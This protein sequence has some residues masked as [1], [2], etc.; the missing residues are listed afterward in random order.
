MEVTARYRV[1][2]GEVWF[3]QA[4]LTNCEGYVV[5]SLGERELDT[6]VMSVFYDGSAEAELA[7]LF[8]YLIAIGKMEPVSRGDEVRG[9]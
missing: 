5:V 2:N 8:A 1:A 3:V 4:I 9:E 7:P 6:S